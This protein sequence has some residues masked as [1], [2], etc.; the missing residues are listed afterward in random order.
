MLEL[1][2]S[3]EK[4]SIS[5]SPIRDDIDQDD[6]EGERDEDDI[7]PLFRLEATGAAGSTEVSFTLSLLDLLA[8][9]SICSSSQVRA[10][11]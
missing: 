11:S 1:P 8:Q 10:L 2:P 5:F 6:E 7:V 3:S 4:L 9:S